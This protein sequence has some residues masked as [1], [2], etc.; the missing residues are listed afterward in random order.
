MKA[1]SIRTRITFTAGVVVAV[2]LLAASLVTVRIVERDVLAAAEEA[3]RSELETQAAE[4]GEGDIATESV[5]G[6]DGV[7]F[8]VFRRENQL[9][10]GRVFL[11]G[12]P[13]ADV[14][15]NIAARQINE[16]FDPASGADLTDPDVLAILNDA[17]LVLFE[18]DPSDAGSFLVGAASLEEIEGAASAVRRGLLVT[19]PL[20]GLVVAALAYWLVGRSLRPVESIVTQVNRI[21]ADR[22]DERVPESSADDEVALL[23]ET[24]NAMLE[25]LESA[26]R[27]LRQFSADASHELRS[28]LASIRAAAEVL[29]RRSVVGDHLTA[30]IVAEVDR[31][32]ALIDNLLALAR[33][34]IRVPESHGVVDMAELATNIATAEHCTISVDGAALVIGDPESLDRAIL[35]LVTNAA[36]YAA[37]EVR[38]TVAS[39]DAMVELVVDDDGPGIPESKRATVFERFTRLDDARSRDSGGAGI[40]L[41]LVRS[42]ADQHGGSVEASDS[43]TLGGARLVLRLPSY[44]SA[45]ASKIG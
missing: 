22:L 44:H 24:M 13:I 17:S 19:V 30:D 15:V 33:Q 25:R 10:F 37:K 16:A 40:G 39:R 45:G 28:P 20:V 7:S 8:G 6:S 35:N 27:S 18:V 3:V 38:V 32:D 14:E 12:F 21:S 11:D 5:T 4:F 29:H 34:D 23:S 43:D 42:I 41:A 36:R 1:R 31:M 26:D 9:V 2:T